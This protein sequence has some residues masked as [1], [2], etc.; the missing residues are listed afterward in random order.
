MALWLSGVL[1]L[2]CC[3]KITASTMEVD[4]CPLAKMSQDCDKAVEQ[5]TNLHIVVPVEGDCLDCCGFLPAV[6][7]KSRNIEPAQKQAATPAKK[8]SFR[9]RPTQVAFHAA[10]FH[11]PATRISDKQRAFV[12]N[13]V[14]RI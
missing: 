2:L 8:V 5:N 12:R 11:I 10:I 3:E 14:F 9:P 1:F 4:S 6:F 7:D 13:C